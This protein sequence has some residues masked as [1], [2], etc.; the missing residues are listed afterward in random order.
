MLHLCGL[1]TE[2]SND[3]IGTEG[4]RDMNYCLRHM[5]EPSTGE[6]R[7]CHGSYCARCLVYSFGPKKPPFCV[8]CALRASG[9]RSGPRPTFQPDATP[10]SVPA[11]G[12]SDAPALF[13]DSDHHNHQDP[14]SGPQGGTPASGVRS[15][16]AQKR[17]QRQAAKAAR[18]SAEPALVGAGS[19]APQPTS[20]DL[21]PLL[22]PGQRS[23]LGR[24]VHDGSHA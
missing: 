18:R 24:L 4:D 7:S 11:M 17:S 13:G 8:G 3:L 22:T 16:W 2:G 23:A 9:V 15:S 1:G 10:T 6:C 19:S 21:E 12:F 20:A 5:E 14:P